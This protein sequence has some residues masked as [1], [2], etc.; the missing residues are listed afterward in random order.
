M[1]FNTKLIYCETKDQFQKQLDAEQ[2]TDTSIVFIKST[3]ELWTHGKLCAGNF[4]SKDSNKIAL[5]LGGSSVE[6]SKAGHTHSYLPLSGGT[7]TGALNFANNTWNKLGDDAYIGDHNVGNHLCIKAISGTTAGIAFFNSSDGAIG[8]LA[9]ANNTLQWNGTNISLS[10]H[11][12]DDRYVNI[13]GDTMTGPLI[14]VGKGTSA[15][16]TPGIIFGGNSGRIGTSGDNSLGIFAGNNITLRPGSLDASSGKGLYVSTTAITYNDN[17]VWH[18]GNDGSGSGMDAD[19]LDGRQA[20]SFVYIN[21]ILPVSTDLNDTTTPGYYKIQATSTDKNPNLPS[22]A[23]QYGMLIVVTYPSDTEHRI[24]QLYYEHK[25]NGFWRRMRNGSTWQAWSYIP[26]ATDNV[27]SASKVKVIQNITTNTNYPIVWS[28][29]NNTNTSVSDLY[30]S[31]DHLYYNP[32]THKL[33]SGG[34]IKAGSSNSY[35]LLGGGGHKAISDFAL[36]SSLNNYVTLTSAQT[37]SGIKTFSSQQKFTVAN[38]TSPFTVSSSTVVT[39]LNADLLDGVHN[40]KVNGYL[41]TI[42]IPGTGGDK[43]NWWCKIATVTIT[44]QYSSKESIMLIT[45]GYTTTSSSYYGFVY[46]KMQ[47][48]SSLGNSPNISLRT[49]GSIPTSNIEGRLTLSSSQ[50]KLDIYLKLPYT[51]QAGSLSFLQG[52]DVRSV[53]SLIQTLPSASQNISCSNDLISGKLGTTTVGNTTT[54]IYLNSGTPTACSASISGN[55]NTIAVRDGSGDLQCRLVRPTYANQT[56]ISGALAYRVNNSSDNYIRFCSDTAAIRTWLGVSSSSHSHTVFKNNVMIKGTNGMSDSASIHLGIG[57]SDTGF[58]WISDGVVQMYSNNVNIGQW[59]ASG[60]NWTKTPQVNG[61]A[62]ALSNHNHDSAYLKVGDSATVGNNSKYLS[63]A[64]NAGGIGGI[65]GDNDEWRIYGRSTA[66]NA[67]YLEIATTDDGDGPIYVRQYTGSTFNSIKRTLT[68]L[69]AS[70]NTSLPGNLSCGWIND[71]LHIEGKN[72][73]DTTVISGKGH[74][75][76]FGDIAWYAHVN[77]FFRPNYGS[78]GPTQANL[79]IQNASAAASNPTYTTT[80]SF[81]TT[82]IGYHSKG[83][84]V[85]REASGSGV[86]TNTIYASNWFR[87]EGDTGWYNQTYGGGWYM[88]DTTWIRAYNNKGVMAIRFD[89]DSGLAGSSWNNGDGAF[90]VRIHNNSNQTPILLAYR[91]RPD[92]TGANR[93]FALE[94]LNSGSQLAFGM[95][96]K[97]VATLNN[98]SELSASLFIGNLSGYASSAG[99][100]HLEGEAGSSTGTSLP[101]NVGMQLYQYY[102][103]GNGP[104][105]YGNFL[106]IRGNN[107]GCGELFLGWQGDNNTS[108][109]WYKSKRDV[110]SW[111]AWRQV[112]FT[113]SN[114]ASADQAI[115]AEYLSPHYAGGVQTNPQTYFSNSTGVKVAMTGVGGMGSYWTDTLWING[116]SSSDV[117]GMCALHFSKQNG[118]RFSISYQNHDNSFYGTCYEVW[119]S[120]NFNPS[121]VV[122]DNIKWAMYKVTIGSSSVSYSKMSGNHNFISGSSRLGTGSATLSL[123]YPSGASKTSIMMSATGHHAGSD[124]NRIVYASLQPDYGSSNQIKLMLGDDS[125]NNDG[126]AIITFMYVG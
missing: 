10:N 2:I 96:G 112:A 108:G 72:S 119:T 92:D 91:R 104:T 75:F 100:L 66:A 25:A 67:G 116:Y 26:C 54:P 56:T 117:K 89:A 33:T 107:G 49:F 19:L 77:Y 86:Y 13:T 102:G 14:V 12:H 94:L 123:S 111:G 101:S 115:V 90:T 23:Y 65:M 32:S 88:Q 37:I 78:G 11:N 35:L 85:A 69:D 6:L 24:L 8:K 70:G 20:S 95:G 59:N 41:N 42:S 74:S 52:T 30:K 18:A 64:N 73:N 5:T 39:N 7:L 110:G 97:H 120:Y 122:S 106:R 113:D 36:A 47:Q 53:G 9:S 125:I 71:A 61:V 38:G 44:G 87:S 126:E 31:W 62:V 60:M 3:G 99:V 27:A 16:N 51:Y 45:D 63:F 93:L 82:G 15:F 28:N 76:I 121:S 83:L 98:K 22:G 29:Q 105:M 55:A 114:V 21:G 46:I 43:A 50:S 57:D 124:W 80:H 58:K 109:I 1:A 34:F 17:K 4:V 68:L 118:P 103:S 84:G 79:I 81:L 40:G 48:Q